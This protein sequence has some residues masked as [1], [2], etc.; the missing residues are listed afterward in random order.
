MGH[1]DYLYTS[2]STIVYTMSRW[3]SFHLSEI[4]QLGPTSRHVVLNSPFPPET[5]T[6]LVLRRR[7]PLISS[8]IKRHV[9]SPSQPNCPPPPW[10]IEIF[11]SSSSVSLWAR[12]P[13]HLF[14]SVRRGHFD[15]LEASLL[16]H[17]KLRLTYISRRRDIFIWYL[18]ATP[19]IDTFSLPQ[20]PYCLLDF[21][22]EI[23]VSFAPRWVDVSGR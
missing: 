19:S 12:S 5:T 23:V 11:L 7:Y 1:I 4:I 18:T 3:S 20:S 6:F 15:R 10:L 17:E 2:G 9:I 21:G 13:Y 8:C 16:I 22:L 14:V